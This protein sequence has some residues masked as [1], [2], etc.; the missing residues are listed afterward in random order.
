MTAS[1][2][3]SAPVTAAA[4][5]ISWIGTILKLGPVLGLLFVLGLFS[6]LT[7]K[8]FDT[9]NNLQLMLEQTAVVGTAALGMTLVIVSG[10]IDLSVGANI[11]LG[12]VVIAQLINRGWPALPA[13]LV[14]ILAC[15]T[16]GV[17]IAVM[18]TQVRLNSFIVTLGLWGGLRAV[19]KELADNTSVVCP[20]SWLDKLLQPLDKSHAWLVVPPGVWI[21]IIATVL[22]AAVLRYTR[23]GRHVFAIGSNEQTARLCGVKVNYTKLLIFLIATLLVG[24]AGVLQFSFLTMGDPTTANGYELNVI[25]AVVIGG[26]SLT[27]GQ[28]SAIGSIVGALMMT[29]VAM[30]CTQMGW[31]NSRQE[32]VTGAIIILASVLDQLRHWRRT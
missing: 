21:L 27:G 32:M 5:K 12:T 2:T 23:F 4:G 19:A 3:Q 26:A 9:T 20:D 16:V 14:G 1:A 17:F 15:G 18:V 24:V 8:T 13:A 10:G 7:P 11:A 28:G 22:V 30:G 29:A 6:V 25:A 31:P